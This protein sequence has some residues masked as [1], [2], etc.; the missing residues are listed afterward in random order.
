[1]AIDGL[2][3]NF[4]ALGPESQA[5][6]GMSSSGN[7]EAVSASTLL[8]WLVQYA[9]PLSFQR[10]DKTVARAESFMKSPITLLD[11]LRGRIELE[12]IR[13]NADAG[14]DSVTVIAQLR[15][16]LDRQPD[17]HE[18]RLMLAQTLA[19]TG[20]EA[21]IRDAERMIRAT[22]E[23]A[24]VTTRRETLLIAAGE[25]A[26]AEIKLAKASGDTEACTAAWMRA[27]QAYRR[28]SH[29]WPNEPRVNS[30]IC[31]MWLQGVQLGMAESGE[32]RKEWLQR[33]AA[34][35]HNAMD[36]AGHDARSLE[37]TR[38]PDSLLEWSADTLD[39]TSA[40]SSLAPR[41]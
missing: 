14:V 33:A 20:E 15:A 16:L 38:Q 35:R 11:G 32:G 7:Q 2:Q 37:L 1:L 19:A 40:K 39:F 17:L 24:D 27:F 8:G 18:A 25:V 28:L 23:V 36:N 22:L 41:P 29:D 6:M 4:R 30:G 10:P 3:A 12:A 21:F 5:W 26:L 9:T 13:V 31:T 34:A